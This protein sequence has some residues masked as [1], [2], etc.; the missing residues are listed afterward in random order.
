VFWSFCNY[1]FMGS[2]QYVTIDAGNAGQRVDNY[3]FRLCKGVPKTHIYKLLRRGEVRVNKKRVKPPFKLSGGDV[4]RLPPL[5]VSESTP[6]DNIGQGTLERLRHAII[7]EDRELLAINKP[8]GM[9]VHGGSGVS[10]GVIEALRQLYPQES[11]ELAH[12]LDRDTSGVMLVSKRRSM[13]RHLHTI[14]REGK[15]EKHYLA[16]VAGIMSKPIRCEAPLRK[17]TLQSGERIAVVAADGKPSV[18]H[19]QPKQVFADATLVEVKLE[20]GRTHQIRVHSQYLHHPVLG[21]AKYGTEEINRRYR[22]LGLKRMFLHAARLRFR[23]PEQGWVTIE[24]PLDASLS[25]VVTLL[26]S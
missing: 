19:F 14:L 22:Q 23:H 8:A 20:T 13:L 3:L 7:Y 10:F 9:A 24:A 4:L 15:A 18:S 26:S 6:V 21:D 25:K 17:N 5:R 12:R 11:L 1:V 16:L 2:V